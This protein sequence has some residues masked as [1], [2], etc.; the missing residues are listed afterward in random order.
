M[1]PKEPFFITLDVVQVKEDIVDCVLLVYLLEGGNKDES[2]RI[3]RPTAVYECQFSDQAENAGNTIKLRPYRIWEPAHG[4][5]AKKFFDPRLLKTILKEARHTIIPSDVDDAKL[6][7]FQN[8]YRDLQLNDIKRADFCY[9]CKARNGKFILLQRRD[10][11]PLEREKNRFVCEGCGWTILLER[12]ERKGVKATPGLREIL[13][14][15]FK[16]I[17]DIDKIERNFDPSWNPIDDEEFTLYDVCDL[18]KEPFKNVPIKDLPVH[19]A[20]K[21]AFDDAGVREL[22]PVQTKAI[23]NGLLEGKDMLVASSTS[24]GKT[25]IGEIAGINNLLAK[26]GKFVFVVPLVALANQKYQDFKNRYQPLGFN[27]SLRVGMSKIDK[28]SR[29]LSEESTS[30][31]KADVIVGTY[32]GVDYILRAGNKERLE[33]VATIVID[34]IQMFK[35]EERG[36]RLDGFIARLK[37]LNPQ[38]QVI[39][40]SATVAN[41]SKIARFL[42][43]K[44]V[45]YFERPVPIERH[46][47][48]CLNEV[49]KMKVLTRLVRREFKKASSFGFKGQ[50]IVFTNSRRTVHEIADY[51]NADHVSAEPYHSGLTQSERMRVERHFERQNVAAVVTTAA[52]GA[53]VDLPASQ[54]IFHSLT[55]GIEWLTVGEFNQMLGRAGRFQKH[56]SGKVYLLVEP[57]KKYASSQSMEEDKVALKL[58]TGTLEDAMP[59]FDIDKIAGEILAF[60]AMQETTTVDEIK[61]YHD[62][63]LVQAQSV[64]HLL[65]HLH[66]YKLISVKDKGDAITVLPDGRA[67]S[68]SF[69]EIEAGMELKKSIVNNQDSVLDI[70]SSINPLKNVYVTPRILSELSKQRHGSAHVSSRFF[71]GQ[72]LDFLSFGTGEQ[73]GDAFKRKKLS[74]FALQVLARWSLDIF[75]CDCGD[76]PYCDHGAK[77]LARIIFNLR[78]TRKMEP[79]QISGYL[80]DTYEIQLY[81][82]DIYEF[83]D[84]LLHGLDAMERFARISSNEKMLGT[85]KKARA[86]IENP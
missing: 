30:I 43:A 39:Y 65:N 8:M 3:Q 64:V 40:L 51:L 38:A 68:E 45:E 82:G 58:L 63:L 52:L 9:N 49:E 70:A 14:T 11:I 36:T 2:T 42:K 34:E 19:D 55:M 78:R 5:P 15:K 76:R 41:P 81:A 1:L 17:R 86:A 4:R 12:L 44:L 73:R 57:G 59:P 6:V 21:R 10:A 67:V 13:I 27:V 20:L 29:T 74:Q 22:L 25:L 84:S 35:D 83:L 18:V 69:L 61:R 31:G 50:S 72:V 46:L 56:D 32:E 28:K 53:G 60:I 79:R 66:K 47:L 37:Y 23:E 80:R 24:S 26:K 85:I 48:P 54:V 77:N 62:M 71:D 16:K 75:T 7:D 33:R